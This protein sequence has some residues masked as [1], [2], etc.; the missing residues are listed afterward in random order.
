M[1]IIQALQGLA[2]ALNEL[3]FFI[4][5]LGSERAYIIFLLIAY[6]AIDARVGRLLGVALLSSFY[7]NFMLKGIIDTPRPFVLEPSLSL[8]EQYDATGIGA[9][10]PSG[11]AQAST[12]FWGLAAVF[13]RRSWFWLLAIIIIVLISISRMYFALHLPIDIIGGIV[14]GIGVILL[15]L[16][17][18]RTAEGASLNKGLIIGLGILVPFI[19]HLIVPNVVSIPESD[20]LM[21]GLAAFITGPAIYKHVVAGKLWQRGL[22]ALIG[23]VLAFVFLI[24]SS[25]VLPEEVKRNA[26]GG[27]I[28]YLALGYVGVLLT[29]W[30]GR[31]LRLVPHTVPRATLKTHA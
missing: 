1:D 21:G 6:L 31:A 11:H 24:G 7:L 29:P 23:I 5:N 8:G 13:V 26:L 12:T 3:M 4:T 15:A 25:L 9:G 18:F 30:L 14:I 22:L 10:F 19:I 27:F 2:P 16:W 20:L 17:V 28:R